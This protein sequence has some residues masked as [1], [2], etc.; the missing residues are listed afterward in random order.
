[1]QYH[2]DDMKRH[3]AFPEKNEICHHTER[4][5]R[6][7]CIGKHRIFDICKGLKPNVRDISN[8]PKLR[9]LGEV[10]IIEYKLSSKRIP[11]KEKT[12]TNTYCQ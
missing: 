6:S 8:W 10:F 7:V 2:I 12:E 3:R 9:A 5:K 11:V 1:M 4:E